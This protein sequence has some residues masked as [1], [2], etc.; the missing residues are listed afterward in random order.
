MYIYICVFQKGQVFLSTTMQLDADTIDSYS[1][2]FVMRF[3]WNNLKGDNTKK[4]VEI[5]PTG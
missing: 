4:G 3:M 2:V 1:T 5:F